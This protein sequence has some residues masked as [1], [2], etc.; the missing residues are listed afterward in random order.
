MSGLHRGG[1]HG[2]PNST[3]IKSR[4]ARFSILDR[5]FSKPFAHRLT[6]ARRPI[7]P[8]DDHPVG[9]CHSMTAPYMVQRTPGRKS[10]RSPCARSHGPHARPCAALLALSLAG[11]PF[12]CHAFPEQRAPV[13]R[14][15]P[16]RQMEGG[17]RRERRGSVRVSA[18][19]FVVVSSLRHL[20]VVAGRLRA[21][22][23]RDRWRR[24]ARA[25]GHA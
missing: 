10:S 18:F 15:R 5:E 3:F 13:P 2:H 25:A 20:S 11:L 24:H 12:R 21:G 17:I 1:P 7:E 9:W 23:P 8:G 22:L 16:G 14:G 6:T 19:A 4:P